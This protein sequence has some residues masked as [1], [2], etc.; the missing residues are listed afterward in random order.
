MKEVNDIQPST[1]TASIDANN[2][3]NEQ[4][5]TRKRRASSAATETEVSAKRFLAHEEDDGAFKL[6]D[7][8]DEVLLE[9]L[10]NCDS[11]TL[12]ALSK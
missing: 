1:S 5:N 3:K 8:T 12:Y 2:P 4:T 6:L 9:I 11:A 7:F 10:Q